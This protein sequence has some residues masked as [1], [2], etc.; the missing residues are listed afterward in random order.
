MEAVLADQPIPIVEGLA[1]VV[2]SLGLILGSA[3]HVK[4]T[5]PASRI[6]R[7]FWGDV[8]HA[9]YLWA[10]ATIILLLGALGQVEGLRMPIW[11]VVAVVV[12][13]VAL[14]MVRLRW[15]RW[16]PTWRSSTVHDPGRLQRRRVA[17][18]S[19]EMALL[20]AAAG[21]LVTYG[22]TSSHT[23]GHPMHWGIALIGAAFGYVIGL[24][25]ATPRYTVRTRGTSSP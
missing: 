15:V 4:S 3:A 11:L 19:W 23:W 24:A 7:I 1:L 13:S 21:A 8:S 20:A 9:A 18:T 10:A 6:V 25:L 22:V 16:G 12:G 5:Q 17:S 14:A 2:A